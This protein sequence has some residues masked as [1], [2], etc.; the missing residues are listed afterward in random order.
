MEH[1][2]SYFDALPQDRVFN[3]GVEER[4]AG[5]LAA[6]FRRFQELVRDEPDRELLTRVLKEEFVLLS[7]VGR[8]G[9][10]EVLFTGYYEP[11][12]EARR[13]PESPFEHPVYGVPDDLVT[14]DLEAFGLEK[15]PR[16]VV[17]RVEDHELIRYADRGEIDFGSG[18]EGPAPVLGYLA[19]PVDVFFLQVQGSGTLIFPDDTRLRAGYAAS[20]G[21]DYRS[22]GRLLIDD[23]LI[24]REEM[25]M[26]AIRAYLAA[27]PD[28]IERVLAYNASYV[29]FRPLESEGG[30]LGC[31]GVPVTAGR[32]IATDRAALSGPGGGVD[33]G[34]DAWPR[35]R[36]AAIRE[37][38]AQSGHR[39]FDP[40]SGPGRS[41]HRRRRG[42]RGDRGPDEQPGAALPVF[43]ELHLTAEMG[44]EVAPRY[45]GNE[46]NRVPMPS[47][48]SRRGLVCRTTSAAPSIRPP[49]GR[50]KRNSKV[51]PGDKLVG[52]LQ[53]YSR[54][55]HVDCLENRTTA[56]VS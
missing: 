33:R 53:E 50:R 14:V 37:V 15:P 42:G 26:Q 41:V 10:G 16:A 11:L 24:P 30:P 19:D 35:R 21:W 56:F 44:R 4:T 23:G 25:S 47:T 8:D 7:S 20:N 27:R 22:I 52:S 3:F 39:R 9:R 18:L 13:E 38:R 32:S 45:R 49:P 51:S 40:R 28:E 43:A 46:V 31:Y 5:Q 34:H 1:S 2:L 36:T 12:I 17:G 55:R 48:P 54:K 29:F 6:G